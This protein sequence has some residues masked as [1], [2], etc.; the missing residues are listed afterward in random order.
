MAAA[1]L[2][3][4]NAT[5]TCPTGAKFFNCKKRTRLPKRRL[6]P[7]LPLSWIMSEASRKNDQRIPNQPMDAVH[8]LRLNVTVGTAASLRPSRLHFLL[9]NLW[10]NRLAPAACAAS[11]HVSGATLGSS[12]RGASRAARH[13]SKTQTRPRVERAPVPALCW[14]RRRSQIV[15]PADVGSISACA[16]T[17][18]NVNEAPMMSIDSRC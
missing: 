2:Y 6:K 8:V 3:G 18:E 10:V 12:L 14:A 7:E 4:I 17:T 1:S 5:G 15:G 16:E 13:N 9:A 11:G